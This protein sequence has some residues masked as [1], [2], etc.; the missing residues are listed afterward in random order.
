MSEPRRLGP[1]CLATETVLRL[2]V[3]IPLAAKVGLPV[4]APLIALPA[5]VVAAVAN[6][7]RLLRQ[8]GRLLRPLL[9]SLELAKHVSRLYV[10]DATLPRI[11][12]WR[13]ASRLLLRRGRCL[14]LP[15]RRA[16]QS[17]NGIKLFLVIATLRSRHTRRA[18]RLGENAP[19]FLNML[20][21]VVEL[22]LGQP[23]SA[24]LE[25]LLEVIQLL[26]LEAS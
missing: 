21:E 7:R 18:A 20:V 1:C 17:R 12:G 26:L 4:T 2:A 24:I 14:L 13:A 15:G 16:N 19:G 6:R 5:L 23:L 9:R 3:E 11:D 10:S 25:H 22:G 8:A